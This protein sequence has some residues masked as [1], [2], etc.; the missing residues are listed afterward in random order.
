MEACDQ[1]KAS[2]I[3]VCKEVRKTMLDRVDSVFVN[4]QRDYMSIIG[5][6]NVSQVAMPREERTIRRQVDEIIGDNDQAFQRVID[7]DLNDLKEDDAGRTDEME[8]D[9]GS[10]NGAEEEFEDDDGNDAEEQFEDEGNVSDD[11]ADNVEE[12]GKDNRD[13]ARDDSTFAGGDTED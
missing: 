5:G 4:M 13:E 9:E 10:G 6:V 12:E 3:A 7:S 8:V 2:L 1:V 11:G